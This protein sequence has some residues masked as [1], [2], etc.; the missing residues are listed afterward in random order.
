MSY[1]TSKE[2]TPLLNKFQLSD[3]DKEFLKK[4]KRKKSCKKIVAQYGKAIPKRSYWVCCFKFN[5]NSS[6]IA[7]IEISIFLRLLLQ[8]Q[9]KTE[10]KEKSTDI[11]QDAK[12]LVDKYVEKYTSGIFSSKIKLDNKTFKPLFKKQLPSLTK[13]IEDVKTP[14]PKCVWNAQIRIKAGM[15]KKHISMQN[16]F[17]IL[18]SL[19]KIKAEKKQ[20]ENEIQ[21]KI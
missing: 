8:V 1:A 9:A 13:Q 20:N 18:Q 2:K 12:K 3:E 15:R 7:S 19:D 21:E 17:M 11:N 16:V 14:A 5:R 4:V 10:N 6:E